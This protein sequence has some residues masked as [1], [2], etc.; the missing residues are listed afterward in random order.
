MP[1][2]RRLDCAD[3]LAGVHDI[4]AH[5]TSATRQRDGARRGRGSLVDVVTVAARRAAHRLRG[6]DGTL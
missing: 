2:A 1:F 3:E 4:I 6:G 5:G